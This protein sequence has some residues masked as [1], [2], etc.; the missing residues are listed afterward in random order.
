MKIFKY[1]LLLLFFA[2]TSSYAQKYRFK[3]S[4]FMVSNKD[5]K[6]NWS[7][8][9]KD[10]KSEMIVTLDMENHRIVV[11]S[12]VIQLFSIV[13]YGEQ[14]TKGDDDVVTFNCVDNNGLECVLSIYTRKK[15]G[16]RNQLYITYQ[17]M[18]IAYNMVLEEDP[19]T[20]K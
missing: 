13:K 7:D 6:G 12:E 20:K 17:D 10:Q 1:L 18:I 5:K 16:N 4:S 9:S 8:W 11:Y 19:L 2:S 3:T 14:E 15:Q